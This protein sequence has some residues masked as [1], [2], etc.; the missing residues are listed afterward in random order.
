MLDAKDMTRGL[1]DPVEWR[2]MTRN[3]SGTIPEGRHSPAKALAKVIDV[4]K[5]GCRTK[6]HSYAIGHEIC[7]CVRRT[8]AYQ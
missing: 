6:E 8:D 4:R 5:R 2:T 7:G 1:L 3:M